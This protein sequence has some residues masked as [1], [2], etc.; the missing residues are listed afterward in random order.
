MRKFFLSAA[1]AL[2]VIGA[3]NS[4]S[5]ATWNF[6]TDADAFKSAKSF[7]GTF[8]QV[9]SGAGLGSSTRD[10]I[11]LSASATN[12]SITDTSILITPFLDGGNAGLGVCSTGF[13]ASVTESGFDGQSRCSTGYNHVPGNTAPYAPG[14]DNLVAPEIL[15]LTFGKNVSITDLFVR[16]GGHGLGNGS[17]FIST[18]GSTFD[19]ADEY[20]MSSGIV[21]LDGLASSSMFWFTSTDNA[22]PEIY[23]S[24]MTVEEDPT[25]RTNPVPVPAALPLMLV[26]VGGLGFMARRKRKAA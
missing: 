18:T 24:T 7:E 14:D 23:L 3:A 19:A 16:N 11:T 4:A 21:N 9:Y 12:T 10:G 2:T 26:G 22:N 1:A 8:D 15:K 25:T 5:A 20:S 17:L 6:Q 13:D